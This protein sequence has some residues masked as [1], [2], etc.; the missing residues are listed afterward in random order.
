[1]VGRTVRNRGTVQVNLLLHSGDVG[2]WRIS[3]LENA[4]RRTL[5]L[6]LDIGCERV[7]SKRQTSSYR[8]DWARP[9]PDDKRVAGMH[10][11]AVSLKRE[12]A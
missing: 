11:P 7:V 2:S 10:E 5:T 8:V 1:V 12:M 3:D 4:Q 6:Q 9:G